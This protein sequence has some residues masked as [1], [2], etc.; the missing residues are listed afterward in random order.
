MKILKTYK[1]LFENYDEEL[2]ESN[3][4][5]AVKENDIEKI[6]MYHKQ[7]IDLNFNFKSSNEYFNLL[8]ASIMVESCNLDMFKLLV[9][10]GVN[11]NYTS[12]SND[13][14]DKYS[15]LS[16]ATYWEKIEIFKYI[17]T[18]DNIDSILYLKQDDTMSLLDII[19]SKYLDDSSFNIISYLEELKDYD[20][21]IDPYTI[22]NY[23]SDNIRN[24]DVYDKEK[25]KYL[26][27]FL[28]DK[29]IDWN[30]ENYNGLTFLEL[31]NKDMKDF[32]INKYS[33][34]YQKYLRNKKAKEFNL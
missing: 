12:L 30:N 31:L 14:G 27:S 17:L 9:D 6:K 20:I 4:I 7:G 22:F 15:V 25:D 29:N 8:Y 28:I 26:L 16:V 11:I 33:E 21:E 24:L 23:C 2:I 10:Y 13:D 3:I 34:K 32:V 5:N 18:L 1:Q 19:F